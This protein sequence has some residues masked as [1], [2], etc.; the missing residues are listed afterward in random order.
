MG[1]SFFIYCLQGGQDQPLVMGVLQQGA[2]TNVVQQF[3]NAALNQT[4]TLVPVPGTPFYFLQHL[5]TGLFLAFNNNEGGQVV[6]REFNPLNAD[7]LVQFENTA[8][9]FVAIFN[10]DK[11]FVLNVLG[12]LTTNNAPVGS[13]PWDGGANAQ[14]LFAT[15]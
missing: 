8:N 3:V 15:P 5:G 9:G 14:W 12:G 4:W 2:D 1:E 11:S 7:E 6:V 10:T 13:W